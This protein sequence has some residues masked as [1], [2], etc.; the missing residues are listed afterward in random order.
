MN[1]PLIVTPVAEADIAE[2]KSWYEAKREGL[3]E[4]FVLD[5]QAATEQIL[6][7]P[8]GAPEVFPGIR[9]V[10]MRRFPYG[11]CYRIDP[12]QIA[13]IAVYH[14]KRHPRGLQARV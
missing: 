8:E 2:A 10:V 4:R 9:R 5:V 7:A 6:R 11:V 3:G 12:D 13:V 14:S 1:L